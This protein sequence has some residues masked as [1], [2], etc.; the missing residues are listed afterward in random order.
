MPDH[1]TSKS[2]ATT[3]ITIGIDLGDR[4][5]HYAFINTDGL[6]FEEGTVAMNPAAF[7]KQFGEIKPAARIAI[8][9]GSQSRWVAKLLAEC[10]HEVIVANPRQVKLIT[11]S[12]SKNDPNDAKLLARLARVDKTLLSPLEHRGEGEQR[13]LVAIRARAL[14]V[15]TRVAVAHS[16][17]GTLKTFGLR[18][19]DARSHDFVARCRATVPANLL[20]QLEGSFRVLEELTQQI[21][22][23][24]E[25]IAKIAAEQYPD[26]ARL[27]EVPGVGVLTALTFVTTI[28]DPKRFQHSR[29]VGSYLGLR[30]AQRQSGERNPQLGITKAGDCYLRALLVQGAHSLMQKNGTDTALRAWGLKLCERGGAGAK[31]RAVVAVARKLAVLLHQLWVS[32]KSY[33]AYPSEA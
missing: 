17:R 16:L 7:R 31:K 12:N 33:R 5:A 3:A 18:L 1:I 20:P 25:L 10:G 24:A 32:G 2:S 6:I 28:G 26:V 14:L 22:A 15:K 13:T 29:D 4:N 30:P 19:P 23:Y 27:C 9:A 8:E 21:D 11:A